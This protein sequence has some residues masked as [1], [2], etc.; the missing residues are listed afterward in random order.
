M[1]DKNPDFVYNPPVNERNTTMNTKPTFIKLDNLTDS[2]IININAITSIE[3]VTPENREITFNYLIKALGE[4]YMK[5]FYYIN[6]NNAW[7]VIDKKAKSTL[8][9][10]VRYGEYCA[11]VNEEEFN[12]LEKYIDIIL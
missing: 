1:L 7:V 9:Y 5:K 4:K 3:R 11:I 10:R 12:K 6:S 2:S 8:C